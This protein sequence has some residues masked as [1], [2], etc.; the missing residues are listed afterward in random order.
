MSTTLHLSIADY[1]QMIARG[2]FYHLNRKIELIRGEIREMN[3]A[4]PIH[5]DLIDYLTHWSYQVINDCDIRI[6][7]QSGLSLA[8]QQSRPEPDLMWVR[9]ARYRQSHPTAN[10]VKLAIEVSD[11][12]LQADLI[13]KAGLYAEAG[14]VEYWIVDA[15]GKCVHVFREP[16]AGEYLSRSVAQVGELLSPI[17]PCSQPLDLKDLFE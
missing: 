6:R 13:E 16:E 4:G 2:A 7:V 8:G 9:A 11:S 12:S 3:P 17:A 15:Q 14:I 10:D 1:D 5:D